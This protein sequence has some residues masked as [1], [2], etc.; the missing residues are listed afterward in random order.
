[1]NC[2][3]NTLNIKLNVIKSAKNNNRSFTVSVT[4]TIAMISNSIAPLA[5]SVKI[6][7]GSGGDDIVDN[8]I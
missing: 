2:G 1:M 7:L 3:P 4:G 8:D 6:G 5:V